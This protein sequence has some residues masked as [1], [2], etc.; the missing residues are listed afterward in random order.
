M[1]RGLL[2]TVNGLL[3]SVL[4]ALA[5]AQVPATSS[6]NALPGGFGWHRL[7]NTQMRKSVCLG[8]VPDAMFT[9]ATM[10]ATTSYPFSCNQITPWSGGAADDLH[11]RLI[12]WGGGHSDYAGNE[13]S[14]LNLDG[15]PA[16]ERFTSP[17]MPVPYVWDGKNWKDSSPTS[18][19]CTTAVS[20]SSGRRRRHATPITPCNTYPIR[21]SC[22][23][24]AGRWLTLAI[25]RR[26]CGRST[27]HRGLGR[28]SVRRSRN[29]LRS[30]RLPTIR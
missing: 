27:C 25:F 24:L 8:E 4:S 14:V 5:T 18:F 21:T 12:V 13:V 17:T 19:V 22:I 20:T 6:P 29:R 2:K 11:H 10:T 26:R 7:H 3:L 1:K 16:W 23:R 15:T 9:D 30:P 28:C